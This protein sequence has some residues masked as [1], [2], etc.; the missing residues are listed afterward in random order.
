AFAQV[1]VEAWGV[2]NNAYIQARTPAAWQVRNLLGDV[3]QL[4]F[5]DNAFDFVYDTSLCYLP[6]ADLDQAI[7]ELFRVSRVGVWFAGVASDMT[8]EVIEAHE[9]L[10]GVQS[11]F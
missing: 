2:E 5:E 1:G 9:L 3:R 6:E 8:R 10:D 7:R 11:L 4:P